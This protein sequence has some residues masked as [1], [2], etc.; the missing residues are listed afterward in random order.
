MGAFFDSCGSADDALLSH[1]F[2]FMNDVSMQQRHV[3]LDKGPAG[4][5]EMNGT[6]C[7]VFLLR[8]MEYLAG[9]FRLDFDFERIVT[10]ERKRLTLELL[11]GRLLSSDG[12]E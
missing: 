7:G 11:Q 12:S 3:A 8:T 1:L 2:T 5:V 6:E 9:D 10:D 4:E